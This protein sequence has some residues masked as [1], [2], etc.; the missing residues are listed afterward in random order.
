MGIRGCIAC[1]GCCMERFCKLISRKLAETTQAFFLKKSISH[2]K[3]QL[4]E[5]SWHTCRSFNLRP[6]ICNR[7]YMKNIFSEL[8]KEIYDFKSI[9]WNGP[10]LNSICLFQQLC[11]AFEDSKQ[12]L[13]LIFLRMSTR[14]ALKYALLTLVPPYHAATFSQ[15]SMEMCDV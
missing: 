15:L 9:F 11:T 1:C 12:A 6:Y 14:N 4:T 10:I 13:L 8:S 2:S 7:F 5:L 3:F